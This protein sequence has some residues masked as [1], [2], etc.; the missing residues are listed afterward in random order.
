MFDIFDHQDQHSQDQNAMYLYTLYGGIILVV[1]GACATI[2]WV[3][4]YDS[5]QPD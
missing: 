4:S 2:Y 3:I 1:L 5:R